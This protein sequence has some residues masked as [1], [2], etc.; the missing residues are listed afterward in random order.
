[1]SRMH[2]I[3]EALR[4]RVLKTYGLEQASLFADG[5]EAEVYERDENTLLKLYSG[6]YKQAERLETLRD[7]YG[8]VIQS[9]IPLPVIQDVTVFPDEKIIAVIE[10]R[11]AGQ[12]LEDSLHH[13]QGAALE[14]AENL[15]LETLFGVQTIHM[16]HAPERY[17]LIDESNLSDRT[18]GPFEV[19]YASRLREKL[20]T[21]RPFFQSYNEKFPAKAEALVHAIERQPQA[22]LS[23]VHGDIFAGNILV[24][25]A[26][27]RMTGI[28]DFGTYT[29]FGNALLDIASGFGYYKMYAPDR[30]A[31]WAALLPK[32]LNRLTQEEDS[33]FFQ[34]LLA[35]AILTSNLYT[36]HPDPR[37]NGHF[38]WAADIVSEASYWERALR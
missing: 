35:N 33:L 13:L 12:A 7:F 18:Q 14:R 11:L 1:M 37:E 30:K 2:P 27:D 23:V 32:V 20:S 24:N 34:Y 8:N 38:Q 5:A 10:T 29:L 25:E 26:L 6:G 3:P 36:T 4:Q 28:I 21:V 9:E 15:Y 17:L 22:P 31:I 19:F 16:K